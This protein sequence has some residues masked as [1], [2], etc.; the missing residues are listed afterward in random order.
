MLEL[1]EETA[2]STAQMRRV[3]VDQMEAL[4]ELN[5]IVARHGRN[6]DTVPTAAPRQEPA[7]PVPQRA[8]SAAVP[9][10]LSAAA[11]TAPGSRRRRSSRTARTARPRTEPPAPTAPARAA[12]AG[13]PSC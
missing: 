4:A 9:A 7:R 6:L 8:E 13:S 1:P 3:I 2:E 12:A 11:T 5:R 10:P